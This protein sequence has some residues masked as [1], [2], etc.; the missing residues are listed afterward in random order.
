[1]QAWSI[2]LE[3]AFIFLDKGDEMDKKIMRAYTTEML[4]DTETPITLYRKY[5]GDGVGVLLESK[6]IQKGRYSFIAKDPFATIKAK[7]YDISL[8][9]NG[10]IKTEHMRALDFVKSYIENFVIVDGEDLPLIGGGFGT[11][12][13]D[14]I[15]QYE[16]LPNENPDNIGVPDVHL[17]FMNQ[18]LIYDHYHQKIKL[19]VLDED[20]L[21]GEIRAKAKLKNMKEEILKPYIHTEESDKEYGIKSIKANT[22]KEQYM[23]NVEKAKQYIYDGDIFQVVLS[24][25]W[26]LE[27]DEHPFNL[28]RK[29]RSINPSPYLFYINFG[30]YQ[31]A[32]SSPEMLVELRKDKV[33][34]CPIAGTRR[35][36]ND[37]S[38][39]AE[40]AKDLLEDEK[41]RAEHV[42]LVDLG[43]NDMGRVSKVKSVKVT[44][45]MQVHNY[46]HVMHLVSTVEGEKNEKEDAFSVLSSFLPAGTLSGAPKIRAMEIIDELEPEKRGVYGGAIGYF[47]YNG[48]MDTCIAI[49]TMLMKGGKV[50]LQAGAGITAK[51]DPEKEDE[52]CENKIR[53]LVKAIEGEI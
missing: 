12:A 9:E 16:D 8:E 14:I 34:T 2:I 23:Q 22:S 52:E 50:Y 15:R 53:A 24:K 18:L 48:D 5:V 45:F 51:S 47:S 4:G 49:R 11:V 36:T 17:M 32:G 44:E 35:K 40:L 3:Q 26:E 7:D 29:L 43:R 46:S 13:Y 41:E 6:E 37:P 19:L 27:T 25:K 33:F 20:N 1:M 31:V 30:E 28:Y 21:S 10:E 42:M 39:D 38:L